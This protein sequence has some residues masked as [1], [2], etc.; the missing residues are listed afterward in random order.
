M[1]TVVELDRIERTVDI[2]AGPDRV[3]AALTRADLLC[4][5]F[6]EAAEIDLR[7][8]GRITQTWVRPEVPTAPDNCYGTF[9]GVITEID[10]PHTFA[11]RWVHQAGLEPAPGADTLVRFQLEPCE[12]GTRVTL[13]E[14]GF[15]A[16]DVLDPALAR[17]GNVDGWAHE[18][19]ELSDLF[20]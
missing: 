6:G 15:A 13:T 5:W 16:L 1:G 8:G 18:L 7:V 4:R 12:S 11:F 9:A 20:R 19:G 10:E 3:W 14:T 2:N 17:E